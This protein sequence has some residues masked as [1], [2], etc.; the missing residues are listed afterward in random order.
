MALT[1]T[2][3]KYAKATGKNYTLNDASGLTLFV[4]VAGGGK[5]WHF[6]FT[7]AGRQCRIVLGPYPELSLKDARARRDEL[8]V[9]LAQGVDP[10][11]HRRQVRGAALAAAEHTFGAVFRGWRDFK[12]LSLKAG[13]Q[14][15]L[16]QIDR[17][18][19]K[20]V[21]PG[22]A[23]LSIFEV[24]QAHLLGVL[25]P[26]ERR[27]AFTTAEKVRTWFKQLFRY[28]MVE[29][30]LLANPA[31]ELAVV[32]M[33]KPPVNHNPFLRMA[34]LPA[35]LQA[36]RAY[37]GYP[38]TCLGLRLL[39]LTGVRTGELRA[40]TPEQFDLERGLWIVPPEAV[41]QL[42][43]S[44][45]KQGKRVQ[46]LPPYTVP[47]PRQAVA[48]VEQLLM[49]MRRR[50]AQRYLLAA[51]DCLKNKISENTLNGAL[52]R[53][54]YRDRLTGHGIRAT[55]STALN[56]IGY[57]QEWIEAQLSHCDPNQVRAAYNHAAYVEQ[58]RM[59]MQAWADRLDRW[60]A[61]ETGDIN[62]R[63]VVVVDAP[64][65]FT[66]HDMEVIE[67]YLKA[68]AQGQGLPGLPVSG[69]AAVSPLA[70]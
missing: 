5:H 53:M 12:A 58:R 36:L 46:D 13:R 41:K 66:P 21:L 33:P 56:E 23:D 45:R 47:L 4:S 63:G 61:G 32:A 50:P 64:P 10:R 54:G 1:D 16:S 11:V 65:A 26:I 27:R 37:G 8:R 19:A 42:Q 25:R 29:K 55:I 44:A 7:W 18:F 9:Q 30:G 62:E 28:A 24:N 43:H 67:K 51:R 39:L 20:D 14:S 35:F 17:I 68:L 3:V 34:E 59:M 70:S 40:A 52:K 57:R 38:D 60:E 15:T 2:G 69:A 6:R 48:I 49:L 22:L 31:G